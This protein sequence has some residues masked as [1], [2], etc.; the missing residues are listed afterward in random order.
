MN[1]NETKQKP[2]SKYNTTRWKYRLKLKLHILENYRWKTL[3][4]ESFCKCL[5]SLSFG[6]WKKTQRWDLV[7]ESRKAQK[8]KMDFTLLIHKNT[9]NKMKTVNAQTHDF[10]TSRQLPS[11]HLSRV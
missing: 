5:M 2:K 6:R 1:R 11:Q 3:Y 4:S 9:S 10:T 8:Q 7:S